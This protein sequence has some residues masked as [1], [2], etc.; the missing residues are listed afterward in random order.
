M[1]APPRVRAL[2][3]RLVLCSCVVVGVACGARSGTENDPEDARGLPALGPEIC[4]G[5][6]DDGDGWLAAGVLDGGGA[7]DGGSRDARVEDAGDPRDGGGADGGGMDAG[8]GGGM[9]AGGRDGGA[10]DLDLFVDEDFRD[11]IGRYVVDDHCGACDQPCRASR[12]N[13][14][15]AHCGLVA[16]SPTCMATRCA[17]G[18]TPSRTGRCVP[19]HERLCLPCADDGDCGDF[20]GAACASLGDEARCT[21]DCALGCPEGYACQAG[22]CEP[23][24]GSCTCE[25]GDEFALACALEDPE[26]NRCAGTAACRNGVLSA[27]TAPIDVCD[28]VDNDCNGVVDD[29]FRDA[30][31]A[32]ILDLRNCGECG[33]DCTL[34]RIPEGDLVCGGDPFAPSCVLRCPDT[35]DGIMPGDRVDADRDIATGCECTVSSTLDAP[36]PVRTSGETLDVNCDGADGI[37]LESLYVAP[38]GDDA[39][40]G[41]P[42][43]PM[44]T[45]EAAVRR[46]SESIG[47]AAPRTHIF[48]ASGTY[49]ESVELRDGVKIHGGYRRDFLALD[50]A[51]FRVEIR[52]PLGTTAPGQAALVVRGAGASETVL[53]WLV[54]RGL[55]ATGAGQAT[56]GVYALDPGPRLSIRDVEIHS[57][58][59][60]AG[61]GGVA[62][63]AGVDFTA[64]PTE[65]EDPR[66]AEENAAR[67]CVGGLDRNRVTGGRGGRNTCGGVEVDGGSG[68]SAG[69][70]MFAAFQ[71]SGGRGQSAGAVRTITPS[72]VSI[73]RCH[74]AAWEWKWPVCHSRYGHSLHC[75]EA[76]RAMICGSLRLARCPWAKPSRFRPCVTYCRPVKSSLTRTDFDPRNRSSMIRWNVHV[77][78]SSWLPLTITTSVG[79]A[80]ADRS[81]MDSSVSH[82]TAIIF[83][84]RPSRSRG[85]PL[86]VVPVGVS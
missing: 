72:S 35:E 80:A 77:R 84:N 34:S 25:A 64:L 14:L 56:F 82:P 41:S 43:R 75:C 70:P 76:S 27:C 60:G 47:T 44:R 36:G 11:A 73:G 33:V 1:L 51:G 26:G 39:G 5:L 8:D 57:G 74:S 67:E 28:E 68:G 12:P 52:A 7:L 19:I 4:N 46:A 54:V 69:C 18:F 2:F 10:S 66:G 29:P 55:D 42:T 13:E 83:C 53:E 62:G 9:D 45:L 22:V 20:A 37:V 40:P 85:V 15:E 23:R 32:Y 21:V 48:V 16:E 81:T 38:D 3:P 49:T 24:S 71:M 59:G 61:S 78:T 65:G 58:V 86:V 63:T 17:A 79:T 30:R 6:D 50:P 31:G